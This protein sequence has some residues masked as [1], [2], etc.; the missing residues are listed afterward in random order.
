M[1]A[2]VIDKMFNLKKNKLNAI[3]RSCKVEHVMLDY[4]E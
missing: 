4:Q 2:T 1:S 3:L